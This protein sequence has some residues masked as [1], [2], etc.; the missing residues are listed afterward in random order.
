MFTFLRNFE[1][2]KSSYLFRERL[3]ADSAGISNA[4]PFL[5]IAIPHYKHCKYL[6]QVLACLFEQEFDDFE[7]LISDDGSPDD[8]NEVIPPLL[9]ASGRAFRYYAQPTNLGY[10]GNVRFCLSAAQGRYVFL[11]GNDDVLATPTTLQEISTALK[12]LEYPEVAFT[13]F[14]DWSVPDSVNRRALSTQI[15]GSG[16]DAAIQFFRTFSFVSGLIYDREAAAQNETDKWDKSVYYQIYLACRILS[17]GGRLGALDISAVRKDVQIDGQT[18]PNYES[19]WANAPWSFQWRHTGLDSVI[20][21]TADAILPCLPK[22]QHSLALRRIIMQVL[23]VTYPSWLFEYRR[24]ANWSFAVGVARDLWPGA[25]LVEYDLTTRHRRQLWLAYW[26]VTLVGLTAPS[27][28]FQRIKG[29]LAET[30]RRKQQTS[31][32]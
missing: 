32:K 5:T 4:T 12:Q 13:N 2:M 27:I 8:S 14:E 7:I 29:R 22:G 20:R 19:K 21:V 30:V 9:Q 11:L 17:K 16:T 26:A 18:V 28:V 24:V 6:Q 25:R 23:T 1:I 10:D 31:G 3:L 15:L